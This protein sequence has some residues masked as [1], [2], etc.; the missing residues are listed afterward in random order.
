[1]TTARA[2]RAEIAVQGFVA[3][4]GLAVCGLLVVVL[5]LPMTAA[6]ALFWLAAIRLALT[7]FRLAFRAG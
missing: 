7:L 6:R 1:M 5:N 3:S 4:G 2:S